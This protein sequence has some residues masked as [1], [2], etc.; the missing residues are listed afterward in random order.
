MH[1]LPHSTSLPHPATVA[2]RLWPCSTTRHGASLPGVSWSFTKWEL[3]GTSHL[4]PSHET[5]KQTFPSWKLVHSGQAQP[6]PI[7]HGC[8]KHRFAQFSQLK[9]QHCAIIYFPYYHILISPVSFLITTAGLEFDVAEISRHGRKGKQLFNHRDFMLKG[10]KKWNP[11]WFSPARTE[12][13][14]CWKLIFM[15]IH[16]TKLERGEA[17]ALFLVLWIS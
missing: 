4:I 17:F 2:V 11:C 15:S 3:Q 8:V 10:K 14:M 12:P 13:P 7:D 6:S 9:N 1:H 16:S 5:P